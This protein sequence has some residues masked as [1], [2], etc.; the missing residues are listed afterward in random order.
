[1][2]FPITSSNYTFGVVMLRGNNVRLLALSDARYQLPYFVTTL[3][4][5]DQEIRSTFTLTDDDLQSEGP[6]PLLRLLIGTYIK[7]VSM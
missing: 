5:V 4:G 2:Q 7:L 1:M 3:P 6:L